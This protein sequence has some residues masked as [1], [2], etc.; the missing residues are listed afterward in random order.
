[1]LQNSSFLSNTTRC[2]REVRPQHV[3]AQT[4]HGPHL[5]C[6]FWQRA[7]ENIH[8]V[9]IQQRDGTHCRRHDH[10]RGVKSPS[11]PHLQHNSVHSFASKRKAV[12]TAPQWCELCYTVTRSTRDDNQGTYSA[13]RVMK[14][15]NPTSS[16]DCSRF[17][18]DVSGNQ[19]RRALTQSFQHP[20]VINHAYLCDCLKLGCA[21]PEVLQEQGFRDGVSI[22]TDALPDADKVRRRKETWRMEPQPQ[23][24][25]NAKRG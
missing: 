12:S 18:G 25:I 7:P 11:N 13:S 20:V 19:R 5:P 16:R 21:L 14:R 3:G 4:R 24:K 6:Y 1:M 23:P 2:V 17:G 15:K 22:Q 9:V 8:V 10:V